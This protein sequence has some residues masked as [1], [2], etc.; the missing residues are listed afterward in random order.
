MG[1][2]VT[3]VVTLQDRVCTCVELACPGYVIQNISGVNHV[4]F[5]GALYA[6]GQRPS[7]SPNFRALA[8][9]RSADNG[10]TW[11]EQN[12]V[13]APVA[14]TAAS[15]NSFAVAIDQ[16]RGF[17]HVAYQDVPAP[18]HL[19]YA[20]FN[21][22]TNTWGAGVDSG[23]VS[24]A[25]GN[26]MTLRSN[27]DVVLFGAPA[28]GNIRYSVISGG[29]W[30]AFTAL[31]AS[32]AADVYACATDAADKSYIAYRR[33]ATTSSFVTLTVGGV[34]SA[35]VDIAVLI[36][37]SISY[38]LLWTDKNKILIPY[39]TPFNGGDLPNSNKAAFWEGSVIGDAPVFTSSDL[40]DGIP[41]V[42]TGG[43]LTRDKYPAVVRQ[44]AG[45]VVFTFYVELLDDPDPDS[46]V[47]L[48]GVSYDDVTVGAPFVIW[49]ELANPAPCA[50]ALAVGDYFMIGNSAIFDGSTLR[51]ILFASANQDLQG[52]LTLIDAPFAPLLITCDSPPS[53]KVGVAYSHTFPASGGTPPY[54]FAITVGSLPPGV[55]LDANTGIASGVPTT[56][57]LFSFTIQVTDS[58]AATATADCSIRICPVNS[59]GV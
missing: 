5:G 12:A 30:G 16:A 40:H 52:S 17:I 44:N 38:M 21:M 33:S 3:S 48:Y 46:I 18:G 43:A 37:S 7:E 11:F 9:F 57:G 10:A 53:G 42:G 47:S 39:S 32:T 20:R 28:G 56:P 34:V 14:R 13:S 50:F 59:Q 29:V 35:F 26:R 45:T 23:V 2:P 24:S 58:A 15:L 55:T 27:G 25:I 31:V 36:P 41:R 19:F 49:D 22:N 6:F 1:L 8:V 51:T 4:V 54:T